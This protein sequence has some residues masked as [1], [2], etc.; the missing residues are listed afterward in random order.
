LMADW[1]T[2]PNTAVGV[3]G[4]P[5]GTTVT[6]LRDN[7]VAIAEGAVNAPRVEA[8]AQK[9]F[10]V[11]SGAEAQTQ[12]FTG[13]DDYYGVEFEAYFGGEGNAG[14]NMQFA[15]STNNGSTW[16]A[17]QSLG[18]ILAPDLQ[19]HVHGTFDFATG[20][21]RSI[22][23]VSFGAVAQQALLTVTSVS[24]AGASLAINAIR[25]QGSV[26]NNRVIA[27]IKPNGGTA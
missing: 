12:I 23:S 11:V 27:L 1:T 21:L 17:N 9:V 4:L 5:S 22:A 10:P 14:N 25:I 26:A 7:P 20:N 16:S 2:L 8:L 3:G 24:M 15:Y 13:L 18:S 6:A 19:A